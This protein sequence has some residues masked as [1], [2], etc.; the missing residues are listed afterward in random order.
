MKKYTLSH[1]WLDIEGEMATV[2]ISHFAQEQVGE[3]VS[4][5][6]PAVN[7]LMQNGS[8]FALLESRK[9]VID[10]YAPVSGTIL[11]V[12]E[13][14]KSTPGLLNE[15]PEG[16]GWICKIALT[17]GQELHHLIDKKTYE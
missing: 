1:L 3:I 8:L 2:G 7:A 4:I 14:L 9:A 12:N 16:A 15:A 10:L 13:T 5:D 17:P 6:L 11:A